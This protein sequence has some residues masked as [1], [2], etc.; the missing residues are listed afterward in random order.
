MQKAAIVIL[1]YNGEETLRRFLPSVLQFSV[2]PVYVADNAST[3]SSLDFLKSNY[4]N[5]HLIALDF[6]FGYAGGYNQAL[7][8]IKGEFEYYI[9]LN[10]DVEVTAG[11]DVGLVT[12]LDDKPNVAG[13]QGKILSYQCPKYF[14]Y[15]GAAGGFIDNFGYPYCRGRFFETLEEDLGQYDDEI[16]VDWVSGA[17]MAIRAELFHK[18]GGFDASYFAHMEEI[19]WCWRLRREGYTFRYVSNVNVY[20]M[21]GATLSHA[22]PKK[23][24]LN[25][26]NNLATL[27]KNLSGSTWEKVYV[28]RVFLDALASI[29]F[30]LKGGVKHAVMVFKAHRDYGKMISLPI[31]PIKGD[32]K[33]NGRVKCLLWDYYIRGKKR[34]SEI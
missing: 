3:D 27:K 11:W 34:Y 29:N 9:L 6:N 2:Y 5:V 25:F 15:A 18:S 13:V 20:H 26:R 32:I 22:N 1:N 21:G 8:Q 33:G 30:L 17:C 4:P 31:N 7:E 24:Y 10:S 14:E 16:S 28:L 19:D 12:Y 23:T